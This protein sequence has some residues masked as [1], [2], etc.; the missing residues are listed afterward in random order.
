MLKL[1]C[2]SPFVTKCEE[3]IIKKKKRR[4]M[5]S[6]ELLE[7]DARE[8]EECLWGGIGIFFLYQK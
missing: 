7:Y 8:E 4:Q 5:K 3:E 2:I 1:K 6:C